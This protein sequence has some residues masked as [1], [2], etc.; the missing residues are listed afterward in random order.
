MEKPIPLSFFEEDI[1]FEEIVK[2]SKSL[3]D[4]NDIPGAVPDPEI[5]GI[6]IRIGNNPVVRNLKKLIELSHGQLAPEVQV[7]FENSDIY[8]ITHAIGAIRFKGSSS[9]K[10]LQYNGEITDVSEA[11][12]IDLLPGTKFK[13]FLSVNNSYEA[14]IKSSGTFHAEV[15]KEL[16]EA[17]SGKSVSLGGNIDLQLSTNSDFVGKLS[18]SVQL[19]V[20]TSSGLASNK[21]TWIINPDGQPLLGDQSLVQTIAVP[22]GTASVLFKVKATAKVRHGFFKTDSVDTTTISIPVTLNP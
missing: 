11:T 22:K 15:P 13:T 4:K 7:L 16:N 2:E 3:F 6:K 14:A 18:F 20:V 10:E 12:T 17:L 19:P 8:T 21:C 1:L 9:L 5:F